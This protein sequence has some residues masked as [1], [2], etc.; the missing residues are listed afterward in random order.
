MAR[1]DILV[2]G[3]LNPDLILNGP[4]ITPAFGQGEV[5]VEDAAFTIGSSA[6]IFATAAAKLGLRVGFVGIVGDDQFG[7]FMLRGLEDRGVDVSPVIVDEQLKTGCSV[8]L[9]R[10]YDRAILTHLGAINK[11][12][13]EQV[14][15]DLL[16]QSEHLHVASYF[17]QTDLQPGLPDLLRRAGLKGLTVSLDTNW[18]P[19][20][21]WGPELGALYPQIDI[22]F[23]NEQEARFLGRA[24]SWREGALAISAKGP[25][26]IVKRGPEGA[27]AVVEDQFI[28]AGAI[29]VD[30]MDT[31]GA[32]DNFNAGF[33]YG[34]LAGW[35]VDMCL[36]LAVACGSLSTQAIGGT[37]YQAGIDEALQVAGI[38]NQN[39]SDVTGEVH[40]HEE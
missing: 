4:D 32:G 12:R 2:A 35:S 37:G 17:L 33:L 10:G 8:I 40:D 19:E 34:Y 26:V 21:K 11:L 14:T 20:E 23:P 39:Q 29:N 28:D 31:T 27:M 36:K 3:E 18:D 38:T 9:S 15:D 16:A 5:L 24:D 25:M 1:Y 30:V 7:Q 22:L 6:A 13:A